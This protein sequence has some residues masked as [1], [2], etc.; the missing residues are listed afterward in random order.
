MILF[1]LILA[2]VLSDFVFQPTDL[3]VW[4]KKSK[5]GLFVHALV[6]FTIVTLILL[7]FIVKGAYIYLFVAFLLAFF[8][9]WID[10]GKIYLDSKYKKTAF[11]FVLDQILHLVV[12]LLVYKFLCPV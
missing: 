5:K 9:F 7:T 10:L 1:Y 3:V 4:K 8:H 11:T 2:H 6:H 12:I